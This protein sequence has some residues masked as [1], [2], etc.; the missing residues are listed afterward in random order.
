M[1]WRIIG[2]EFHRRWREGGTWLDLGRR[3]YLSHCG[4]W[5]LEY[6]RTTIAPEGLGL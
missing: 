4:F 2:I 1:K 6:K 3:H 5:T